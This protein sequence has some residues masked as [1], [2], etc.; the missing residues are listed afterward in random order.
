[1]LVTM[2][3]PFY[4]IVN[5]SLQTS[6]QLYDIPPHFWPPRPTLENFRSVLLEERGLM[7]FYE[8]VFNTLIVASI[9]MA[10]CVALGSITG[11]A[12]ARLNFKWSLWFLFVLIGTQMV[13]PLVDLIPLYIIFSRILKLVDTKA[14]L[15]IGYTGWLL[16]ISVWILYGYFQTIPK[17]LESAARIDGCTR[18]QALFRVVMPLS[19]PGIAATAI[20]VFI[21]STNEFLFA[22]IF[23]STRRSITIPVALSDMI[24]KYQIRYGDMTAGA[25]IAAVLP[26]VLAL[27]FQKYL[28]QSLT[29]GGIKG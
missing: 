25:V 12:L 15:V 20:Y 21:S 22:M 9:C 29:A 14:A 24:G 17:D 13:P 6:N 27:I 16:P 3:F 1:V 23:A 7:K 28:V 2:L 4:W 19:A 18:L 8:A 10:V 5:M 11:Y 26:V